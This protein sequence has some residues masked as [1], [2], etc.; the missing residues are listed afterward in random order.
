MTPTGGPGAGWAVNLLRLAL[1]SGMLGAVPG[2][3]AAVAEEEA[4][5]GQFMLQGSSL[6][7]VRALPRE[8]HAAACA[9]YGLDTTSAEVFL[10][11]Q[12]RERE[13]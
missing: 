12:A 9:R 7:W 1:W 6:K 11:D 2:T 4:V 10:P 3:A 5:S 13:K 8:G